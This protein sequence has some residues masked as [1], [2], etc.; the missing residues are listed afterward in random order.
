MVIVP[1][2]T[3]NEIKSLLP[4]IKQLCEKDPK[5][6]AFFEDKDLQSKAHVTLAHKGAHG[7]A[8]VAKYG[9]YLK[10]DVPVGLTSLLFSDKV[11]ALEASLGSVDGETISSK[12]EWPHVTIWTAP[13]VP[14][15]EANTLP[16][17]VSEGKAIR[18]NIIPAFTISG[19]LEFY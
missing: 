11:A 15:K 17:L 8:A 19:T 7:V 9:E 16:E 4:V 2:V 1:V 6:K 14:P 10:R 5:I 18:I 3:H 13:G 12:N